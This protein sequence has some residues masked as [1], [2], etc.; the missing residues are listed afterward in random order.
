MWMKASC[1]VGGVGNKATRVRTMYMRV[2]NRRVQRWKGGVC[3]Q[4]PRG[5]GASP[6]AP[7]TTA[8]RHLQVNRQACPSGG[9]MTGH[10]GL[11]VQQAGT[12]LSTWQLSSA[13]GWETRPLKSRLGTGTVSLALW[14]VGQRHR[15]THWLLSVGSH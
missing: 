11:A 5:T 14:S 1:Y 6:S 2:R 8:K 9:G 3:C 13:G 4:G 12:G 15:A 10:T 7:A